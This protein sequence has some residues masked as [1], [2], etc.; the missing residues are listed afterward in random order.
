MGRSRDDSDRAAH[1]RWKKAPDASC[2][3]QAWPWRPPICLTVKLAAD[4][5]QEILRGRARRESFDG[6]DLR[7]VIA[8]NRRLPR[9]P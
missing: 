5:F 2:D 4:F 3:G 8:G 9:G 1:Q 7:Q 6:A